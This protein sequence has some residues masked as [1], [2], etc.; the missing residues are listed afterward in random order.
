MAETSTLKFGELSK[1]LSI[2]NKEIIAKLEESGVPVKGATSLISAENASFILDFFSNEFATTQ[3]ELEQIRAAEITV[4]AKGKEAEKQEEKAQEAPVKDTV[5]KAEA[6]LPQVPI[7]AESWTMPQ[8]E[9]ATS[10][11]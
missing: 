6:P 2:T 9:T 8:D 4:K 7:S 5:K 1:K 3:D 10:V 11:I